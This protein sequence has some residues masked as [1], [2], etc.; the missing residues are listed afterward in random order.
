[1]SFLT[2]ACW[3]LS[4]ADAAATDQ[5]QTVFPIVASTSPQYSIEDPSK[6]GRYCKPAFSYR[7]NS[8]PQCFIKQNHFLC[9]SKLHS[10]RCV[11]HG[12]ILWYPKLRFTSGFHST[13][14]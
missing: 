5:S 6:L 3:F 9:N 8:F 11:F 12:Y 14:Q 10:N 4:F 7:Q 2:D 1:M 13:Q